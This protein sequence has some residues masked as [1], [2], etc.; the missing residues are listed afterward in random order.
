MRKFVA[1]NSAGLRVRAHPTLQSEQLGVIKPEGV[2]SF[3]EEVRNR[4]MINVTI[5]CVRFSL[6]CS[7]QAQSSDKFQTSTKI[8]CHQQNMKTI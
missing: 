5:F 6:F 4:I 3:V 8:L 7:Q 1:K 2:I